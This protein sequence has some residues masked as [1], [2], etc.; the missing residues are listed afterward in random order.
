MQP[1]TEGRK[2]GENVTEKFIDKNDRGCHK[3]H[4]PTE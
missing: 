3:T 2:G 4:A 1:G